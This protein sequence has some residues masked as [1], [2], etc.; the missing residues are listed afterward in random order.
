M[1]R[2]DGIR[3]GP[4]SD[5]R[6]DYDVW[7]PE[8]PDPV[9]VTAAAI[10]DRLAVEKRGRAEGAVPGDE[11]DRRAEVAIEIAIELRDAGP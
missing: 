2:P 5:D 7:F 9:P 1:D 8:F 11:R 6:G 10:D 3:A 4:V